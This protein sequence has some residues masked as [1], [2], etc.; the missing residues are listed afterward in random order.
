MSLMKVILD[1]RL[2]PSYS[3]FFNGSE[4]IYFLIRFQIFFTVVLR[5]KFLLKTAPLKWILGN[6]IPRWYSLLVVE[7]YMIKGF[8]QISQ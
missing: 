1:N 3:L 2:S 4:I 5:E 8:S 7:N 6:E